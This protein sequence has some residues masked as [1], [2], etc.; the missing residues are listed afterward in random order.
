MS[1]L[2]FLGKYK[3][4]WSIIKEVEERMC[5]KEQSSLERLG[6]KSLSKCPKM[7]SSPEARIL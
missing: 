7:G 3:T 4:L 1:P 6:R 2:W 5:E